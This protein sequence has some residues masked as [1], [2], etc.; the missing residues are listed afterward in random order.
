MKTLT[1]VFVHFLSTII[2]S[3]A[4]FN[5]KCPVPDEELAEE[6]LV[7]TGG[8]I[9]QETDC[10]ISTINQR[11]LLENILWD[12]SF[13]LDGQPKILTSCVFSGVT[14]V[15]FT[16][17]FR[18]IY[19]NRPL[20]FKAKSQ[21]DANI[22]LGLQSYLEKC[23][24]NVINELFKDNPMPVCVCPLNINRQPDIFI[25]VDEIRTRRSMESH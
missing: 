16:D 14:I 13:S 3:K 18:N 2:L 21:E 22:L 19:G 4:P 20:F 24:K 25:D 10:P 5:G 9:Q 17:Y 11:F 15:F 8:S 23:F 1:E 12:V 7:E 6:G